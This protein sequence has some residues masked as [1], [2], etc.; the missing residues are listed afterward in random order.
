MVKAVEVIRSEYVIPA[1]LSDS[2]VP[3]SFADNEGKTGNNGFLG[4]VGEF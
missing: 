2:K 4:A 3:T 1:F